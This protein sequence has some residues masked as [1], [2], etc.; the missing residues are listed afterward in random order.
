M[1][2]SRLG[3]CPGPSEP[4]QLAFNSTTHEFRSTGNRQ[5]G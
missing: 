5:S 1:E 3:S 4:I 2:K